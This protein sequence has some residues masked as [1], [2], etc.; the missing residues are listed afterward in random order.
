MDEN[1]LLSL[2]KEMNPSA[3]SVVKLNE[4]E[5]ISTKENIE[6]PKSDVKIIEKKNRVDIK[7]SGLLWD[8][9]SNKHALSRD[10]AAEYC[11]QKGRRLPSSEE[12]ISAMKELEDYGWHWSASETQTIPSKGII[13]S[14]YTGEISAYEKN[15]VKAYARCVK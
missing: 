6:I 5:I 14:L 10:E 9:E 4:S 12:L 8:G 7:I 15:E 2:E 13:V 3:F 1:S 11:K